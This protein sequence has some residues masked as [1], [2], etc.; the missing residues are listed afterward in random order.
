M[1]IEQAVARLD[2]ANDDHFTIDGLPRVDVISEILG[3]SVTRQQI[4]DALPQFVRASEVDA[5]PA[6]VP[7]PVDVPSDKTDTPP[8]E[9][10][11]DE[12]EVDDTPHTAP[13]QDGESVMNMPIFEILKSP[14][15]THR[16]LREV[17]VKVAEATAVKEDAD[18]TLKKLYSYNDMLS[19]HLDRMVKTDPNKTMSDIHAYLKRGQEARAQKAERARAFIAAGTTAK[20]VMDE[21]RSTS[22]LDQAMNQR[23]GALSSKRPAPRP[24]IGSSN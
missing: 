17:E 1:N 14:E 8:S 10:K 16:A 12:G 23:N 19:R 15:L 6:S 21:L 20:D 24:L 5:S 9:A 7:V 11:P 22:K 13:L 3:T 2:P 18:A 4:T